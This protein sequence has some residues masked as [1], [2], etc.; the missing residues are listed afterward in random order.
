MDNYI[1]LIYYISGFNTL[2]SSIVSSIVEKYSDDGK[3]VPNEE[4]SKNVNSYIK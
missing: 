3:E 4:K 2:V 1:Y